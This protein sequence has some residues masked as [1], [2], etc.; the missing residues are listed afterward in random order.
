MT[1]EEFQK[2]IDE[3]ELKMTG[4]WPPP[5]IDDHKWLADAHP[6]AIVKPSEKA[7]Q[8]FILVHGR[9]PTMEELRGMQ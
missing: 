3:T 6:P 9:A 2:L 8:S 7:I 4:L 1:D 5:N